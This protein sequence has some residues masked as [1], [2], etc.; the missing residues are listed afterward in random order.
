MGDNV[1]R[2]GLLDDF[3]AGSDDRV[4]RDSVF[5][6]YMVFKSIFDILSS[7]SMSFASTTLIASVCTRISRRQESLLFKTR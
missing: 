6:A 1:A 5:L 3:M 7:L 4:A 2:D